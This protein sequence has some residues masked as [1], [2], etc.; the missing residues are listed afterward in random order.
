[1]N[2]P[3]ASSFAL[4]T[5]HQ[6]LWQRI[7]AFEFDEP[8]T[9]L[10]FAHRLARENAW[11]LAFARRVL[12]EYRR[13]LFL[14]MVAGHPVTPSEEVDQAWHLHMV[15]TR[16]YWD[17][18]CANVLGRPLHHGPTKGGRDEDKK[19]H[20][21]YLRTL[22]S[23]RRLFAQ[24]P[25]SDVWPAPARR[26]GART[27]RI[28][29]DANWILPKRVCK[30]WTIGLGLSLSAALTA[31]C[32]MIVASNTSG[33][34]VGLL[35][36]GAVLAAALIAVMAVRNSS[37]RAAR[38]ARRHAAS[39]QQHADN[40]TPF[41]LGM[42]VPNLADREPTDARRDERGGGGGEAPVPA[43]DARLI[44]TPADEPSGQGWMDWLSDLFGSSSDSS[45]GDSSGSGGDGGDGGGGGGCGGGCG[46]D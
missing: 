28:D 6:S 5:E 15:Y 16:S 36:S 31:G 8:G 10:T 37:R 40:T 13:F 9:V 38:G 32:G 33:V 20:D 29:L 34:V 23:Y 44:E 41:M 35:L 26:F 3:R 4:S 12:A 18:L 24:E 1:M 45:G 25:P 27:A 7:E 14:A 39:Q 30:R 46:G 11:P 21:W 43:S 19:F 22:D 17:E 42:M 2:S